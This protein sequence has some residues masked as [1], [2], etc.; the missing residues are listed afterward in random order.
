[1]QEVLSRKLINPMSRVNQAHQRCPQTSEKNTNITSPQVHKPMSKHAVP[2][3]SQSISSHQFILPP[4]QFK[5]HFRY[6]SRI[7]SYTHNFC[8]SLFNALVICNPAPSSGAVQGISVEMS[9]GSLSNYPPKGGVGD[10]CTI[11]AK[12]N[13]A[14][15]I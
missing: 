15:K 3:S 5:P 8:D 11:Y 9:L 10:F 4:Y 1:M 7:P 2:I 13:S 14:M 12:D 6:Y